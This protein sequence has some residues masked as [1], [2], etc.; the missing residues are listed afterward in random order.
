MVVEGFDC[1]PDGEGR[2][3]I[4]AG[5]LWTDSGPWSEILSLFAENPD[6]SNIAQTQA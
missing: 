4:P 1:Q 6:V 2:A 5:T 3:T